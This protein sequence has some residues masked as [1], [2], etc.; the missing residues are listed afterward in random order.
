MAV[1]GTPL[2][3]AVAGLPS[4]AWILGFGKGAIAS[5]SLTPRATAARFA[6]AENSI[7]CR[8]GSSVF[9][10]GSATPSAE[11]ST[12]SGTCSSKVTSR[13]E[14]RALSANSISDSRHLSCFTS[15]ARASSVSRSPN[16]PISFAAVLT[17]M[18]RM[19]GTLS[20]GS[21]IRACTS[22]TFSGGTPKRSMT[23]AV[24][25]R[26]FFMV[27]NISTLPS[28]TSCIKSLSDDTIVTLAPASRAA[29]A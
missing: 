10:S 7:F 6:S 18:P 16:S 14:S 26:L 3:E 12:S 25:M 21:P 11:S 15:P 22:T 23:S 29:R 28:R 17:P 1:P 27:S 2:A 24:P 9:G 20:M 5:I 8:K 19:P 13:A 4:P